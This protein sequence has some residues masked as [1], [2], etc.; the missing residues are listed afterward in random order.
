MVASA[1][2]QRA[3]VGFVVLVLQLA[4]LKSIVHA[5]LAITHILEVNQVLIV[6]LT[7]I[8]LLGIQFKF[9]GG[10]LA[11]AHWRHFVCV[12]FF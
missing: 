12:K 8:V 10:E 9:E 2:A 1:H 3:N 5:I 4:Y 6:T 11:V 7:E